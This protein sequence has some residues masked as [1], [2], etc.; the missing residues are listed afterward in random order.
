M[1]TN[2]L[3]IATLLFMLI[4]GKTFAE[5]PNKVQS[6]TEL[7]WIPKFY[8]IEIH[9]N[10]ELHLLPGDKCKVE[11][12]STYF[13]HNALVQ[14]ENGLLRITC[15][16][17]ERLNVWVTADDLRAIA[18][19]DN[20]LV[21]TEGTFSGIELDVELFNTAKANLNLDCF[22]TNVKLNDRSM[23]DIRNGHA[24]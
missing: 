1:K 24:I 21:Q 7:T 9:G 4:A 5:N 10:V 15:Y 17:T 12:N 8:K 11:M 19:Y 16:R 6:Y 23:A 3:K 18:A 22:A 13:D 14:V 20:V 2:F